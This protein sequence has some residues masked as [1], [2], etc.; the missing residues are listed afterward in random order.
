LHF[1]WVLFCLY[2]SVMLQPEFLLQA[3][4]FK[5][6]WIGGWILIYLLGFSAVSKI[7]QRFL[8]K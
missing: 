6:I 3:D 4:I 7:I 8:K 1:A 2:F 5:Y